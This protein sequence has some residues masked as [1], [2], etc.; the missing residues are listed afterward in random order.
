MSSDAI[1]SCVH[2]G[3]VHAEAPQP[4]L[5]THSVASR[6]VL[7]FGRPKSFVHAPLDDDEDDVPLFTPH[8]VEARTRATTEPRSRACTSPEYHGHKQKV[9]LEKTSPACPV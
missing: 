2:A 4:Q 7:S 5:G 1:L 9:T 8:A 3:S 6:P